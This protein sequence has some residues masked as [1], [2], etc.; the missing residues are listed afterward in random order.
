MKKIAAIAGVAIAAILIW[1]NFSIDK[2]PFECREVANALQSN[3][4]HIAVEKWLDR[5]ANEW[6]GVKNRP[7]PRYLFPYGLYRL[8]VAFD[9]KQ[10]VLLDDAEAQA[11][12]DADYKLMAI[13][14]VDSKAQKVV[15]NRYANHWYRWKPEML[16]AVSDRSGVICSGRD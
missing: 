9:P 10:F 12:V 3:H 5:H 16:A 15:I 8:P 14:L 11:I 13:E 1:L 6:D 2:P 4:A 7:L